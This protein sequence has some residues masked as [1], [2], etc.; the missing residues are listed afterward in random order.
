MPA[1]HLGRLSALPLEGDEANYLVSKCRA[2][3]SRPAG[4]EVLTFDFTGRGVLGM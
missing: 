4:F 3:R 2:G 1:T